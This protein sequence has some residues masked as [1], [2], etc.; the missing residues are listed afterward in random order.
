MCAPCQTGIGLLESF[1]TENSTETQVLQFLEQ[2][3]NV[4][5]APYNQVCIQGIADNGPSIIQQIINAENPTIVCQQLGLC[6]FEGKVDLQK[7]REL[8]QLKMARQNKIKSAG[9]TECSICVFAVGQLEN[10]ISEDST[11][12]EI[13]Q[14]L[15]QICSMLGPFESQ[16]MQIVQNVPQYI[17]TLFATENPQLVCTQAGVCVAPPPKSTRI[18]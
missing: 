16:C 15:D 12:E 10:Y 13:E 1:I 8:M 2:F 14:Y 4:L 3:C 6:T 17:N 18:H 7:V 11:E 9:D 5:P